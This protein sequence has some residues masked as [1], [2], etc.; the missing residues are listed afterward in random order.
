[1]SA[2]VASIIAGFAEAVQSRRQVLQGNVTERSFLFRLFY[3]PRHALNRSR[4]VMT[5]TGGSPQACRRTR[6][7]NR[8]WPAGEPQANPGQN[9][10]ADWTI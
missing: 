10:G 6:R 4:S 8:A 7:G 9:E 1:V 2:Q 3:A 5:L